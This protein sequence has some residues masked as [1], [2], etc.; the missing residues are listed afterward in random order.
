MPVLPARTLVQLLRERARIEPDRVGYTFLAD[1][2]TDAR[3]RTYAELDRRARA[4]GAWLHDHAAC[5]DRALLL[6]EEGLGYL[7]ALFG[8]MYARV[9]AVPVHPPDPKRLQR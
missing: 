5:G 9:Y 7:D 2:E 3:D 1:G 6:F 4:V 8:C